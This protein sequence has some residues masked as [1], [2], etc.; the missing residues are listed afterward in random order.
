M[1]AFE[2]NESDFDS[3]VVA[4]EVPVLLDFWSPSCGPCRAIAP[5]IDRL[6]E[7]FGETAKMV[8]VNLYDNMNLAQKLGVESLPTILLFKGGK[9]VG[10]LT[11]P[12]KQ[13]KLAE[14]VKEHL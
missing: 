3:V 5:M 10:R 12:Q 13:D 2:L 11:G 4:S 9:E 14:L 6:A 1:K 8:K 7:E